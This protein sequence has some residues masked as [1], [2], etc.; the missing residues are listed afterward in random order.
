MAKLFE[1]CPDL[2]KGTPD[3]AQEPRKDIKH[4]TNQLRGD[5]RRVET[6]YPIQCFLLVRHTFT[7]DLFPVVT[8]VLS[9]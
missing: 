3:P 8:F 2:V 1:T 7:S 9:V 4:I 5:A 6:S